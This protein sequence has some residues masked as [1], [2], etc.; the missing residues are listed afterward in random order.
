MTIRAT[1]RPI[2]LLGDPVAHSFSPLIHNTG[3]RIQRLDYVYLACRVSRGALPDAV[4]GLRALGFAGANVTIPHKEAMLALVDQCTPR[5]QAIGAINTVICHTDA[6][7]AV[8]LTGDNTDVIG[9]LEPLRPLADR[10]TGAE[11]VV[12]GA[13]GAARAVVYAL[14]T[15]FRPSRLTIVART[16]T[17]AEMLAINLA[18]CDIRQALQIV[19]WNEATPVIRRARLIVNATPLGMHPHVEVSPWPRP[20]DFSPG[21]IVY[22]LVYNPVQTRLLREAA[23]RGAL[24]I[25]GLTMLIGQAAAAYQQWTGQELP[26]QAV[27]AALQPLLQG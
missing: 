11:M 17:R 2:V 26:R 5:A 3:F 18:A 8:T 4:A 12:L 1:T 16:R 23:D 25:D 24:T 22:D 20:S 13:G 9:F 21:Q 7:G 15:E 6:Q 10:L 14:L 19:S 27:Q